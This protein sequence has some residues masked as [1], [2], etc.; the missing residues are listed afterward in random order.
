MKFSD[1]NPRLKNTSKGSKTVRDWFIAER[2]EGF[3][4]LY[5]RDDRKRSQ[6]Y[7]W[8]T[9]DQDSILFPANTVLVAGEMEL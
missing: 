9:L 1:L 6:A 3:Q 4:C 5:F 2:E 7:P 8:G